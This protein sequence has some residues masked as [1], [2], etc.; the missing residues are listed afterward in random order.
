MRKEDGFV[1]KEME[2]GG[3]WEVKLDHTL[4]FAEEGL[5]DEIL[6][7]II[8]SVDV[9]N[10]FILWWGQRGGELENKRDNIPGQSRSLLSRTPACDLPDREPYRWSHKSEPFPIL[11][12]RLE[13]IFW[14]Y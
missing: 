12:T 2:L 13:C 11:S 6:R 8:V 14:R 4:K 9:D 7:A 5:S 3:S 1:F 10:T